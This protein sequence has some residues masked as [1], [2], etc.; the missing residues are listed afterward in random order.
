[1]QNKEAPIYRSAYQLVIDVYQL[2]DEFKRNHRFTL[3]EQLKMISHNILDIII[4][5]NAAQEKAECLSR[6]SDELDRLR[7]YI[8]LVIDL[9]A[10]SRAKIVAVNVRMN[11]VGRQ[12]GGWQRWAQKGN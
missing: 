1:M 11:D 10:G 3:G 6:L 5:A 9:A 12:I 8:K 2:V 4:Q 7:L